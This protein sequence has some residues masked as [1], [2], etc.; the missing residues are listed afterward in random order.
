M[1]AMPIAMSQYVTVNKI[2]RVLFL[3][4]RFRSG[5][6]H[7]GCYFHTHSPGNL[8]STF[9]VPDPTQ[10]EPSMGN[11]SSV[12]GNICLLRISAR[13][14]RWIYTFGCLPPLVLFV[15]FFEIFQ[16]PAS[17]HILETSSFRWPVI[18]ISWLS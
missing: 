9:C 12:G 15:G 4:Q 7:P 14:E 6:P 17:R 10:D 18:H 3:A 11:I 2:I 13:A 16:V 5:V 1:L 8:I